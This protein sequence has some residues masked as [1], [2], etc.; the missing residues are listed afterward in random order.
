M[1]RFTLY[2]MLVLLWVSASTDGYA[3]RRPY[4][5]L[6][7]Q[8]HFFG[9]VPGARS[10]AMAKTDVAV[11]GTVTS[12]WYNPA[13]VGTIA[14]WEADLSTSGPFYVLRES[15]YY[16]AGFAK[17]IHPKIVAA[18]SVN[19]LAIGPTSFQIDIAG[20][21]YPVD[22][23]TVTDFMATVAAEP[24]KGLHVGVNA[25]LFGMKNFND[26]P[27]DRTF[28]LDAGA[29]YRF[30]LANGAHLQA[31]ASIVNLNYAKLRLTSPTG[32]TASNVFPVI[33]RAGVSYAQ[34][35][36]VNIPGAGS[37]S[38]GL[39]VTTEFQDLFNSEFRS[40]F[41]LGGEAVLA[42]VLALRLGFFTLSEDDAGFSGNRARVNDFTYGFGIQVPVH[43]ISDGKLPIDAM[44]DYYSLES[45]PVI[46][47]GS[48]QPNKRGFGLRIVA[49]L[50]SN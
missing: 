28:Y 49:H 43:R 16:F 5:T 7:Q 13:G 34:D 4:F 44:L 40:A 20:Q 37:Q 15:D 3:Q 2:G 22:E 21:D 41:R 36:T 18:L 25:H 19:Q 31:G 46:F 23:P 24:L 14:D 39:L 11:G 26:V 27:A 50:P 45:P 9:P 12:V 30:E 6:F 48:R 33:G 32:D 42:E 8:E 35:F 29:L 17:R 38:L 47:S 1:N 10:E